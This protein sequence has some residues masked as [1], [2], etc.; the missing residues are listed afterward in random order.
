M[1]VDEDK[2]II[3]HKDENK[4]LNSLK[5]FKALDDM[6]VLKKS[7]KHYRDN[8][9]KLYMMYFSPIIY[10][11]WYIVATIAESE[12]YSPVNSMLRHPIYIAAILIL[13]S[14]IMIWMFSK[15]ITSPIKE[16]VKEADNIANGDLTTVI[17]KK[18]FNQ[19]TQSIHIV[20]YFVM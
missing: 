11:H 19:F 1:I 18:H 7:I 17:S 10:P 9:N 8:D 4:I 5:D 6:T 15:Y 14:I 16:I 3:A 12:L 20:I 2:N 13:L